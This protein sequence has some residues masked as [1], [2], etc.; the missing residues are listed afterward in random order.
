[1]RTTFLSRDF[2]FRS[3]VRIDQHRRQIDDGNKLAWSSHSLRLG[4]FPEVK[5]Q[6]FSLKL[7]QK[8]HHSPMC[9]TLCGFA[10]YLKVLTG[11]LLV[12]MID[13]KAFF[14]ADSR[15]AL[16]ELWHACLFWHHLEKNE[17]DGY[18]ENPFRGLLLAP[19]SSM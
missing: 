18:L 17:Y 9:H 3:R 5:Q 10:M 8:G 14:S 19:G 4:E 7:Y 2:L 12:V 13:P 15:Q 1:M 6:R 16:Y 11:R